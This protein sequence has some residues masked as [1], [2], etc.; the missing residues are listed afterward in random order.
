MFLVKYFNGKE[1][2]KGHQSCNIAYLEGILKD[3]SY[4]FDEGLF[5]KLIMTRAIYFNSIPENLQYLYGF[6][7]T[8]DCT[9]IAAIESPCLLT[10]VVCSSHTQAKQHYLKK[11]VIDLR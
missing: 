2:E 1:A 3:F 9:K 6:R 11:F 8:L 7:V 5:F 10:Y 4:N